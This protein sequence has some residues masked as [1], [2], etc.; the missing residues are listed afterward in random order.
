MML[1]KPIELGSST[2][3]PYRRCRF[4]CLAPGVRRLLA[5]DLASPRG[6]LR[7]RS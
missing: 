6:A 3:S 7:L 4:D 1:L 2:E 5:V